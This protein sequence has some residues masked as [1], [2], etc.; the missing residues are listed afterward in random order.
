MFS[1][2]VFV[3]HANHLVPCGCEELGPRAIIPKLRF[4][5]VHIS[6]K[7]DDDS[8]AEAAEVH[9]ESVQ[10]VL[11]SELQPENATVAQQTPGM[12]LGR[13]G[14]PAQLTRERESLSGSESSER[15]HR[16]RMPLGSIVDAIRIPRRVLEIRGTNSP[17]VPPLP[18]GEGDRG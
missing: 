4:L 16:M 18:K 11:P 3:S 14:S 10:H 9:D 6:V 8:F 7:L 5:V 2:H 13:S 12:T 17:I 1:A 15:V